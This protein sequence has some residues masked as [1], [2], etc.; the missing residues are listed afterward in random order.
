M[1]PG[2]GGTRHRLR[3]RFSGARVAAALAAGAALGLSG[4]LVQAS[5]RNPLAEPGLLASPVEPGWVPSSSSPSSPAPGSD[6]SLR[7]ASWAPWSPSPSSMG[8]HGG[9]E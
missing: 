8:S 7:S 3:L 4:T 5:A 2:P 9:A 6:S 1:V